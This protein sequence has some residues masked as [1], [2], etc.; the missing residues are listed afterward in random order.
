MRW[1]VGLVAIGGVLSSVAQPAAA[2][3]RPVIYGGGG[4]TFPIGEY[5]DPDQTAA[6]TGWMGHAGILFPVGD[7]GVWVAAEGF[8]GKNN[9]SDTP[10]ERTNLFGGYG[11]LGITF[12]GERKVRPYLFGSAGYLVHQFKDATGSSDSEGKFA[13]G[14]GAGLD[15]AISDRVSFYVESRAIFAKESSHIPVLAGFSVSLGN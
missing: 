11:S 3:Q 2:Q 9:H 6:K 13:G 1:L 7:R 15:F 10:G 8:Y 14:G 4:V 5:G 12:N